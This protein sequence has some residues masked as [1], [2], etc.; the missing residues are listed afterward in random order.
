MSIKHWLCACGLLMV[1][2]FNG[3]I[4]T[5]VSLTHDFDF[6]SQLP[7]DGSTFFG[8]V[9]DCYSP[10]LN[11][12]INK[13]DSASSPGNDSK[14]NI[15]NINDVAKII[16]GDPSK[17]NGFSFYIVDE[18]SSKLEVPAKD[19]IIEPDGSI[20]L[21]PKVDVNKLVKFLTGSSMQVCLV[22]SGELGKDFPKVIHNEFTFHVETNVS[23]GI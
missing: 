11:K 13:I 20:H 17:I 10:N 21:T 9:A 7:Q 16:G 3:T 2:C 12:T 15:T 14:V 6:T 1:S 8:T 23:K 18:N 5:D 19:I 22:L 4:E